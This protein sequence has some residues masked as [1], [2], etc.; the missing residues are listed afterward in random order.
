MKSIKIILTIT[1]WVLFKGI[2]SA[3]MITG[4]NGSIAAGTGGTSL[5]ADNCWAVK[6]NPAVLA[7][8]KNSEI[9]ADHGRLFGNS[10]LST[11]SAAFVIPNRILSFGAFVNQSG[12]SG[13][14]YLQTG[15]SAAKKIN[16][17]LDFGLQMSYAGFD[18]GDRFYGVRRYLNTA[19]GAVIKLPKNIQ[20][21]VLVNNLHNPGISK[22][23]PTRE[24]MSIKAGILY[25]AG[26]NTRLTA[27]VIQPSGAG[28]I[29]RLGLEYR[30]QEKFTFRTGISDQADY[31]QIS[32]GFGYTHKKLQWNSAA[33]WHPIL[34]ISPQT[35]LRYVFP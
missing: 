7:G 3:Q 22:V 14:R 16:E 5:L 32:F 12:Y 34:G 6:N 24:T 30:Y 20:L 25:P 29:F 13:F 21:G 17:Q 19:L 10:G 15:I 31:G 33:M 27:E 4:Y 2:L 9:S 26:K 35:G 28:M 23:L 1:F 8:M 18:Y 11:T